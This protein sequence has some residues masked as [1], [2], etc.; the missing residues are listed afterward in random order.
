MISVESAILKT[1]R[2]LTLGAILRW[3]LIASAVLAF[4]MEP[5]LANIGITAVSVLLIVGAVWIVLSFRS[6]RGSRLAADSSTLIA[7]GQYDA[8]EENIA[9]IMDT[10]SIFRTVKLM[11]LH[12]LAVLRHAQN[13]WQE[14]AI[15]CRA[16]LK[17][18]LGTAMSGLDRSSRLI[19]AESLLE[20]GDLQGV[21]E[22]LIRLYDQRLSLREALNL[23]VVEMD[24][25]ARVGAW[26]QMLGQVM[27]K[28]DMAEMLPTIP[29]ARTQA[30][31][32]LAA[33]RVGRTDLLDWLRKRVELLTDVQ[34]LCESRPMLKEVWEG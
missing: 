34:K 23:V 4:L 8:A 7:A 31:L 25:L 17:Q 1:R 19:L 3:L 11:S 26:P 32:A 9:E 15:L 10:F 28:V 21:Y 29:A 16:L 20:L 6:V 18:R 33:K 22:N 5:L 12:H 27:T 13:R 14:S 2:S 30:F 24:Y